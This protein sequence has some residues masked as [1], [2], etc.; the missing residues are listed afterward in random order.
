[1]S[2]TTQFPPEFDIDKSEVRRVTSVLIVTFIFTAFTVPLRFFARR[3]LKT[4]FFLDDWIILGALVCSAFTQELGHHVEINGLNAQIDFRKKLYFGELVSILAIGSTKLSILAFYWRTFGFSRIMSMLIRVTAGV[5][6]CGTISFFITSIFQCSPIHKVWDI[7]AEGTCINTYVFFLANP[8]FN[9]ITNFS[10]LVLPLHSIWKLQI[11]KPKKVE[12][13]CLLTL[14]GLI[15]VISI[16][17]LC[18]LIHLKLTS[19][20]VTWNMVFPAIWLSVEM[21]VGIF[22]ACLPFLRQL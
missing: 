1:I 6:V 8:A 11:T 7:V 21:Q 14:G 9:I 13:C 3:K 20:D 4:P 10:L 22:C 2:S 16:L 15:I 5:V 17:R 12:I 18:S 19:A